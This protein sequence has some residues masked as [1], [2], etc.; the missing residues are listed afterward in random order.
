MTPEL[1]NL[2]YCVILAVVVLAGGFGVSVF[3][4][5][6]KELAPVLQEVTN[7]LPTVLGVLKAIVTKGVSQHPAAHAFDVLQK[8]A[9]VAAKGV[10]Q[11]S[12]GTELQSEEK[13]KLAKENFHAIAEG[14]GLKPSELDEKAV[15]TL[16]ENVVFHFNKK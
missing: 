11:V 9:E 1:M 5:R 15:E 8:V 7:A 14:V 3:L 2:I 16:I 13:L 10:E 6:H 12:Q 4:K